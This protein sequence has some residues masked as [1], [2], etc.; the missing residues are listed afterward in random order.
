M[1]DITLVVQ[2]DDFGMCHAVNAGI[3]KA[4]T[5]GI[6]TEATCMVPCP[7]FDEAA[8]LAKQHA[9]PVA[10]H[11]TLTAEW[12]HLRWRP[13]TQGKSLREQDGTFHRSIAAAR[14]HS[15]IDEAIEELEA[16]FE[17]F[18]QTGLDP[19][20]IDCHMGIVHRE[21]YAHV[22]RTHSKRFLHGVIEEGIKWDSR[23]GLSERPTET[24]LAWLVEYLEGLAPGRHVLVAHVAVDDPELD[25]MARPEAHNYHWTRPYRISDLDAITSPLAR[26]VVERRGIKLV[27]TR[28]V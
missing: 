17:R 20:H 21:A 16:Q 27:S 6:L 26:E 15:T 23:A 4:F 2:S 25:A 28:E 11:S 24:K 7:W 12:D 5:E 13:L 19:I 22:C 18:V 14:E 1:S 3:V 10:M 8:A 9:I